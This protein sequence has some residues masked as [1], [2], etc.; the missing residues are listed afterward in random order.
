[1]IDPNT[2][3]QENNELEVNKNV[4]EYALR[5]LDLGLSVIPLKTMSKEPLIP[6]K[7]FQERLPTKEEVREWFKGKDNNIGIICGSIS[8]NLVV[9]DFDDVDR[10]NEWYN[11][12]EGLGYRDLVLNTWVVETG[13]GIHVY[14]RINTNPNDFKKI[15]RTKPKLIEGVDVKGEGGYVVA[16][17]SI[18]PSGKQYEFR[19]YNDIVELDVKTFNELLESLKSLEPKEVEEVR[20]KEVKVRERKLS[21]E[22]IKEIVQLI[23]P[24]YVKE[25]RNN[26]IYSLLGLFIKTGVDYESAW[27]VVELLTTHANDEEAKLRFY[28]VD[29]HYG[30]RVD[31]VGVE[32][33]KGVS[34]LKEELEKVLRENGVSEDEIVKRVSET[35]AELYSVLGINKAPGVAWLERKGGK[36]KKWVAVGRQGIYL[37]KRSGEDDEPTVQ[38][39]SNAIL[40]EVKRVKVL[41]LDIRNMFKVKVDGEEISG[42]V[43]EII[44]TIE[45]YYGL[46]RSSKYAIARLIDFMAEDEEEVFYSP[47]PWVVD[48]RIVFAKEPGYTPPWKEYKIWNYPERDVSVELKRKALECIKNLV[49]AYK[50]PSKPSLVLSYTA[51]TPIAHYI[52]K[53][54]NIAFHTI[55]HGL[56]DSGKSVL[57]DLIK[58]LF[59]INWENETY[60]NSDFT[61]RKML[62]EASLPAIIDELN[63]LIEGY[64][65]GDKGSVE[66]INVLH[67]SATQEVLRVSGGYQYGG[68]FLAVRVMIGATN[69]DISLVPWQTDKFIIVRISSNEGIDVKKAIGYT[70]KTMGGEVKKTLPIIGIELLKEVEKLLSKIDELKTLPRK[71]LREKLVELGYEAWKNLY[72]KYGLTPFPPPSKTETEEEKISAKEQYNDFFLSYVSKCIEGDKTLDCYLKVYDEKEIEDNDEALKA[73]EKDFAIV[74]LKKDG[75]REI[76]CKTSFITKFSKYVEHYGLPRL[77]WRRLSEMLD[78][79]KT[80]R[81]VGGVTLDN[82]LY[83]V[84]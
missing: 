39:V 81:K 38:I 76:V 17:P 53:V 10:F 60:P 51:I 24:Y 77:G 68:H 58:L 7:E 62:S 45:K 13:K 5:Y 47:G 30:K 57:L 1:M 67:R 23:L 29:Y 3:P 82:L 33:L 42:V 4:Y 55:I 31:V 18:H 15:F 12:I 65:K 34:G 79:S 28:L 72:E 74:L 73:L 66:A 80:N 37:F 48:G 2:T 36:V 75:T 49:L 8:G 40:S 44:E 84:L 56:E 43:D 46:E 27:R 71:E 59:N 78:M 64:S 11:N 20:V 35:I 61:A 21:E 6:W 25:H 83:R 9:I 16:P 69:T 54:L 70:P 14:F 52:K 26:I 32:K 63:Q 41:G 22:Q 50:D 19:T